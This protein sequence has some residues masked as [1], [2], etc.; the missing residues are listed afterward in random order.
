MTS[1]IAVS[2]KHM[3]NTNLQIARLSDQLEQ[4]TMDGTKVRRKGSSRADRPSRG[5]NGAETF[6]IDGIES[7]ADD[8]SGSE[9]DDEDD[10]FGNRRVKKVLKSSHRTTLLVR[11]WVRCKNPTNLSL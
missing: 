8:E 3:H 5:E 10:D 7:E 1:A 9:A 2:Q 6:D 4:L 11:A